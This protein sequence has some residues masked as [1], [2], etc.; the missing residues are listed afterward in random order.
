VRRGLTLT[1]LGG[2]SAVSWS[3]CGERLP[4]RYGYGGRLEFCFLATAIAE[5]DSGR[6]HLNPQSR[7]LQPIHWMTLARGQGLTIMT[8]H[9]ESINGAIAVSTLA[10]WKPFDAAGTIIDPFEQ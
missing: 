1:Q 5:Y 9:A 8:M 7:P 2:L 3:G 6:L 4:P 10:C